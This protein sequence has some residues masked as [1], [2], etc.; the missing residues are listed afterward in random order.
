[1]PAQS[2]A[3][4]SRIADTVYDRK[5]ADLR[6]QYRSQSSKFSAQSMAITQMISVNGRDDHIGLFRIWDQRVKDLG[7]KYATKSNISPVAIFFLVNTYTAICN[8]YCKKV[9]PQVGLDFQLPIET[10]EMF[11]QISDEGLV[12]LD[13]F[14]RLGLLQ[15]KPRAPITVAEKTDRVSIGLVYLAKRLSTMAQA[16]DLP[17]EES[18]AT[19]I[20]DWPEKVAELCRE[21]SGNKQSLQDLKAT[22]GSSGCV[23]Q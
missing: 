16:W 17:L 5:L 9:I 21:D 22:R 4:R 11:M 23:A 20:G 13:H 10:I 12:V 2:K 18:V 15:M 1:M 7:V 6:D 19:V 14:S 8:M 3:P